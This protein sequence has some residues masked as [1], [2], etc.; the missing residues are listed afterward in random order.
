MVKMKNI[1][2]IIFVIVFSSIISI[3]IKRNIDKN[4]V[5][6]VTFLQQEYDFDT[7]YTQEEAEIYFVYE[8][9]G[10]K[11]LKINNVRSSCG[12]TIPSWNVSPLA[13]SE[14]DSFKVTYNI[15]NKGYFIKEVMVYSNSITSPDR[16]IV[17][18]YVPFEE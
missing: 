15:E 2:I 14:R 11:D 7:L 16:L 17:K 6:H 13:P 12:C 10:N 5:S 9:L 8:N 1:V 4:H 3:L 18:G